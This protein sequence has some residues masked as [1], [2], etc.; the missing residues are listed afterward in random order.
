MGEK[1]TEL[2]RKWAKSDIRNGIA[3]LF[4][5][6]CLSFLFVIVVY[7]V[8]QRNEN[9]INIMGGNIIAGLSLILGYYF[10]SSKSDVKKEEDN[11]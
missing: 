7:P 2:I 8:P 6:A 9:L 4:V 11:D 1:I 10:G 5:L 3:V